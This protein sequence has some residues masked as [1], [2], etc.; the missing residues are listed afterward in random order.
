MTGRRPSTPA[1]RAWWASLT[2]AEQAAYV[3]KKIAEKTARRK[4]APSWE[5]CEASARLDCATA[6][7]IPMGEVTAEQIVKRLRSAYPAC[8]RYLDPPPTRGS[9]GRAA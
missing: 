3:E 5:W 9:Q 6:Y 1:G 8:A 2:E 7:G 4:A